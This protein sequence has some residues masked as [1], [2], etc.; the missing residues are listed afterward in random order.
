[1][2]Q[3]RIDDL[4]RTLDVMRRGSLGEAIEY[5]PH[6]MRQAVARAIETVNGMEK[7]MRT[8]NL[9]AD[10]VKRA[11][12]KFLGEVRDSLAQLSTEAQQTMVAVRTMGT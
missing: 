4:K 6:E 1:M 8:L 5:P 12:N 11:T 9:T 3:E 2:D 7:E 10:Q